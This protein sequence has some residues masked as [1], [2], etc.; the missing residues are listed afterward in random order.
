MENSVVRY[1]P[2]RGGTNRGGTNRVI[3][4]LT[5]KQTD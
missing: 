2:L 1:V 4:R 3:V 5:V